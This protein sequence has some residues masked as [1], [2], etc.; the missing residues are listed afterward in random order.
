MRITYLQQHAPSLNYNPLT[1]E[2]LLRETEDGVFKIS[3]NC[4]YAILYRGQLYYYS[5]SSSM[6]IQEVSATLNTGTWRSHRFTRMEDPPEYVFRDYVE[7][8]NTHERVYP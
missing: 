8:V 1:Y 2:E 4:N 7:N 5:L 3:A 6:T